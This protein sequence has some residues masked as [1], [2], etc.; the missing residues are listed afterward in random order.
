MILRTEIIGIGKGS[1]ERSRVELHV[2]LYSVNPMSV[3]FDQS[4]FRSYIT[5]TFP[6]AELNSHP[7]EFGPVHLRFELGD[8]Q[9]NGSDKRIAQS[10]ERAVALFQEV[11][12]EDDHLV[13][14][15]KDW[16]SSGREMWPSQPPRHLFSLV[17][18]FDN[19]PSSVEIVRKEKD[20][21]YFQLFV[22]AVIRDLDYYNILKGIT[23]REQGRVPRI[24]ESVYFVST[25]RSIVFYMYDDR[26]CVVYSDISNKLQS[27][28]RKRNDWLVN[29]YRGLFDQIFCQ[30]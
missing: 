17:R 1:T 16:D 19:R 6:D 14:I 10:T 15:I 23:H 22:P 24:N 7:I 26:G 13:L 9:P 12:S 5:T 27:L 20:Y 25:E 2:R 29:C 11:F 3:P 4:A 28:Y 30:Q 21:S 18:D 8:E